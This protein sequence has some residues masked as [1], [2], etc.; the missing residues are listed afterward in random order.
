M[1]VDEILAKIK[2][3]LKQYKVKKADLFGSVAYGEDTA[4]SDVDLLVDLP[5]GSSLFDMGRLKLDLEEALN[6]DVDLL[7]YNSVH[8]Y[9]KKYVFSKTIQVV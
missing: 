7:T 2:P 8:P 3:V 6:K 5:E 9:I 4:E 1:G